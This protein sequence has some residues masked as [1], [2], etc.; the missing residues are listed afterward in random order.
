M[1]RLKIPYPILVEGKYDKIK[2][3]G[4]VDA[5]IITSDGFGLF[6]NDEKRALLSKLAEKTKIIVLSDSD[7]AGMLIRSCVK[8]FLPKDKLINVY[9]P[10]LVGKEKRKIKPSKEGFVG[11]EGVDVA[12]LRR[13]L[14]PYAKSE[15]SACGRPITKV[16]MYELGLSGK[17]GAAELRERV[18]AY[19]ELP[20]T[21]G[22]NA[23]LEAANLISNYEEFSKLCL[24]LKA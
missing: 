18:C 20:R 9:T 22:A 7:S 1:D 14:E 17:D 19:F 8:G 13:L 24:D 4:I 11:V 21:L 10:Q 3:S 15:E 23:L 5:T 6:K 16:D 2:L 12:T